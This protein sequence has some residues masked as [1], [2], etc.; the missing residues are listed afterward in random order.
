[1]TQYFCHLLFLWKVNLPEVK[2]NLKSSIKNFVSE[3]P[4]KLPNELRLEDLWKL[5]MEKKISKFRQISW[6]YSTVQF[7]LIFLLLAKYFVTDCSQ[8]ITNTKMWQIF[9][10]LN[11]DVI[12]FTAA[13]KND[14]NTHATFFINTVFLLHVH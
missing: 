7:C 2:R 5:K 4:Q 8:K 6:V 1:M 9:L 11:R 13:A 12:L 10:F 3:L 14:W